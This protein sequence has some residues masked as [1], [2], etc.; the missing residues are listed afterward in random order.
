MANWLFDSVEIEDNSVQ[1]WYDPQVRGVVTP[2]LGG[3][4]FRWQ[5]SA[6]GQPRVQRKWLLRA[7]WENAPLALM[8]RI[9][10][11][12]EFGR[13]FTMELYELDQP[14]STPSATYEQTTDTHF[15]GPH[16]PWKSFATTNVYRDGLLII[17]GYDLNL[18]E[19]R[20]SFT[21]T[22]SGTV[23]VAYVWQP[24]VVID[25]FT[26]SEVGSAPYQFGAAATF[27]EL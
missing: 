27:R 9:S 7:Q 26:P 17:G 22:T 5:D 16:R 11:F 1:I 6:S 23:T 4:A 2:L 3:T 21:S 19:G 18:S 10:L 20:V 15:Y 13:S 14:T 8:E 25:D 12:Q 24:T